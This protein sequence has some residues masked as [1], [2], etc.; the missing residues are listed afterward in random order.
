MV[1]EDLKLDLLQLMVE[2]DGKGMNPE[3]LA[4]VMDPFV[5]SRTTRKVGLG[6]PLLKAA[7]EACN[8]SFHITSKPGVGTKIFAEFQHSHIDRM[9]LGDLPSTFLHLLVANPDIHWT[10]KYQS[11]D[12]SFV[13]DDSIIKEELDGI[14][15]SEPEI[16]DCLREMISSGIHEINPGYS[17][18]PITL[19]KH[20]L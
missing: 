20:N 12:D 19:N 17:K 8:G 13:F 3:L 11:A 5:T 14:S 18:D 2:D 15:L 16:L 1:Q 4:L 7:C 6:I 9:P 10:F